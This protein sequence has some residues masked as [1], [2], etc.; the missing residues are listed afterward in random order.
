MKYTTVKL[1]REIE[2]YPTISELIVQ[3]VVLRV[4]P[5]PL[6]CKI[7]FEE[8]NRRRLTNELDFPLL[9][10]NKNFIP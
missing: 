3:E 1:N 9:K 5:H 2:K 7:I 10:T 6:P 4:N 8:G